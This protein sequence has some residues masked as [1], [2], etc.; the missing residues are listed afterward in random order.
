MV[1]C[2]L[3]NQ[4]LDNKNV[5]IS[6]VKLICDVTRSIFDDYDKIYDEGCHTQLSTT[7]DV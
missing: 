7:L 2:Q 3:N 4:A 5:K 1:S 6:A